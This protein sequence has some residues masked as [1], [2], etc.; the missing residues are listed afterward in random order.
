MA[1]PSEID[2]LLHFNPVC[3]MRQRHLGRS[4][5]I[6]G[7]FTAAPGDVILRASIDGAF[8]VID[9]TSFARVTGPLP[10]QSALAY[11]RDHGA[12]HI[13]QQAVDKRGRLMGDP[14]RFGD[15]QWIPP[16]S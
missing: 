8:M 16:H 10:L 5:T 13:F 15:F 4:P 1:L 12:P 2:D 9:A 6:P 11:A 14:T 7:M 3:D